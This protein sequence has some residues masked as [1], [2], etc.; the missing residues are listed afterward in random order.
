M[1]KTDMGKHVY[2]FTCLLVYLFTCLFVVVVG[3][4]AL[5]G[6]RGG[7]RERGCEVGSGE[8]GRDVV[9]EGE[10]GAADGRM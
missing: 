3:S 6:E 2:L 10:R 8:A 9:M 5:T 1:G 7:E 4:A